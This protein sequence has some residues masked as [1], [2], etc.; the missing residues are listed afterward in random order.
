M[1]R[2]TI[3][4]EKLACLKRRI[5]ESIGTKSERLTASRTDLPF[6]LNGGLLCVENESGK[7]SGIE[8]SEGT[9]IPLDGLPESSSGPSG[10]CPS[11]EKW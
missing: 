3:E 7:G 11:R 1:S 6:Y 9:L 10:D 2:I 4:G 8:T 5:D